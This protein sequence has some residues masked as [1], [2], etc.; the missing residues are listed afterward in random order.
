MIK[1]DVDERLE[2]LSRGESRRFFAQQ[3][4]QSFLPVLVQQSLRATVQ[5]H[6]RDLAHHGVALGVGVVL[7]AEAGNRSE[8][9]LM[10]LAE[11]VQQFGRSPDARLEE[12]VRESSEPPDA[13]IAGLTVEVHKEH[14]AFVLIAAN[15]YHSFIIQYC[16][17]TVIVAY[18]E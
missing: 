10:Q 11:E 3:I 9:L 2:V 6:V 18:G 4:A 7:V 15:K 8:A 1:S 5:R 12:E 16:T 13:V 14:P 17:C